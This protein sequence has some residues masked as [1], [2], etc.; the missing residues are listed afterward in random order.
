M[1]TW[2]WSS[3]PQKIAASRLTIHSLVHLIQASSFQTK[4]TWPPKL[5]AQKIFIVKKRIYLENLLLE[6]TFIQQIIKA[7]DTTYL[8]AL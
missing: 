6:R 8:A 2:A 7:M 3:H 1:P 5:Q 4:K